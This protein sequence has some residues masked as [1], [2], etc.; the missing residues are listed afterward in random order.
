MKILLLSFLFVLKAQSHEVLT[1]TDSKQLAA[2]A[3]LC[4]KNKNYAL[5]IS[6]VNSEGNLIYFERNEAAYVGSIDSSLQKARS[7]NAFRR[8]TSSFVEA[9]KNGKLGLVSGENIVAIEGGVPIVRNGVHLG[10]IGISGATAVE[11]EMCA[12][13][14]L[15]N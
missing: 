1:L 5:S 11:D 3:G 15:L 12:K 6:I 2:A 8:P 14:A 4:G 9:V 10:A 13:I 7:S